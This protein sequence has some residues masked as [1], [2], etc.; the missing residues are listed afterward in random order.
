M[1]VSAR[2]TSL[3]SRATSLEHETL[4]GVHVKEILEHGEIRS[5]I[6][7]RQTIESDVKDEEDTEKVAEKKAK[8]KDNDKEGLVGDGSPAPA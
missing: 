4:D 5:P 3:I 8:E 1:V 6:I 7:K 2:D